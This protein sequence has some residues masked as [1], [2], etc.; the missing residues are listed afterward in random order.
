MTDTTTIRISRTTH[1]ELSR[2]ARR[3]HETV[4]QIVS[5]ALR[6]I[7]QDEIGRELASP[8]SDQESAWLDADAG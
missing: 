4:D 7:R 5:R 8:L 3:R 6:L 1:E 2:L